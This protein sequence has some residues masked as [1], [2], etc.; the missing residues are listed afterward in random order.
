MARQKDAL[1]WD[2]MVARDKTIIEKVCSDDEFAY[3][4]VYNA[5]APLLKKIIWSIY[6]N[7]ADFDE[8]ANELYL[9]LKKP[10]KNG[11]YWHNLKTFDHRTSLFDWIK[12]VATRLF[13]DRKNENLVIP[14]IVID[15]GD[16][17]EIGLKLEKA[18]DRK[19]LKLYVIEQ[20][21]TNTICTKLDIEPKSFKNIYNALVRK[22]VNIIKKDFPQYNDYL[23]QNQNAYPNEDK[24]IYSPESIED[25]IDIESYLNLM[26]NKNYKRIIQRLYLDEISSEQMAIELNTTIS[27]VYNLKV[28]ALDQLRDIV[29]LSGDFPNLRKYIFM[30]TNDRLRKV[31][32]SLF[33][34]GQ[35][36]EDIASKYSLTIFEFKQIKKQVLF[37]L[38]KIIYTQRRNS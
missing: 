31:A 6:D 3:Y 17:E 19:L 37:E 5:C 38:K 11:D 2:E 32:T 18:F 24:Y 4:F 35:S 7:D 16:I 27:N 22:I 13:H 33:V 26:P 9:H 10:G 29:I 14:Q 36:Y 15:N 25:K 34:N 28:R 21:D 8:L 30:I 1:T 12:T 20:T 23:Y